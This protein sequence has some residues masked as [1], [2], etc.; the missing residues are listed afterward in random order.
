MSN[1]PKEETSGKPA[2]ELTDLSPEKDVK[3][4]QQS[5]K[6]KPPFNPQP[7]PPA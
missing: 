5:S 1:E 6:P 3:G 4:G 7:D 2:D